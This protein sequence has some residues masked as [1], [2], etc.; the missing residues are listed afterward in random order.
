MHTLKKISSIVQS[1]IQ[2]AVY[3]LI[4]GSKVLHNDETE[5]PSCQVLTAAV[6]E[7]KPAEVEACEN[8][9]WPY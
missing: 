2:M 5:V 8:W 7:Q 4:N 9:H 3:D 6:L 1:V